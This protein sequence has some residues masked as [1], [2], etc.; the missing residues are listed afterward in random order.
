MERALRK[1]EVSQRNDDVPRPSRIEN[2]DVVSGNILTL[3]LL[4]HPR[5]SVFIFTLAIKALV[6]CIMYPVGDW[7]YV[8][9]MK[10]ELGMVARNI[11]EG[12]GFSSPFEIGSSP[13]AWFAPFMPLLWAGIFSLFGLFSPASLMV[14]YG[15]QI[16]ARAFA[17]VLYFE[18]ASTMLKGTSSL[19]A[20][21]TERLGAVL[22]CILISAWPDHLIL[23]TRPWYWAWQELGI[24]AMF[25]VGLRLHASD[26]IRVWTQLGVITGI[27][28][29][30]NVTPLPLLF[31]I[32]G[33]KLV[34]ER[35]RFATNLYRTIY[36]ACI[37]FFIT[38]P[39]LYRNYLVFDEIVPIRSN[40]G[41]ELFVGNSESWSIIQ[42]RP[43]VHPN[44]SEREKVKYRS[45]GELKYVNEAS[46]NAKR[47][48]GSHIGQ[49]IA[50]TSARV[51]FFWLTDLFNS[52]I[53]VSEDN[54][55]LNLVQRVSI[56][57]F[58]LQ[59][60]GP[61]LYALHL[62]TSRDRRNFNHLTLL[63]G[64]L[65]VLPLP[66][67][68]THVHPTYQSVVRPY[69]LLLCGL[70][71]VSRRRRASTGSRKRWSAECE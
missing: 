15:L 9:E 61:I 21:R 20:M 3:L 27:T 57:V 17:S 47:Y 58:L 52:E 22:C 6:I 26:A 66:H 70:G 13:T 51:T 48:I 40:F 41:V 29:L 50:R 62:L 44:T 71:L 45:E 56:A 19:G 25:L 42:G 55:K 35:S 11:T 31:V 16:I 38:S 63:L 12:R 24:A 43:S 28:L 64:L 18:I 32:I 59:A 37:V 5:L 34:K 23:S 67:Y 30:I 69:L 65:L 10:Y 7:T 54:E 53:F 46:K 1:A 33:L 68:I 36:A 8:G 39:W 49:F 4:R 2:G 14:V 60:F